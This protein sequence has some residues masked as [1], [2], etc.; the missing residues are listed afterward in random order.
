[1]L[2]LARAR[3]PASRRAPRSRCAG[4][5]SSWTRPPPPTVDHR[6]AAP[7]RL[8]RARAAA[9]PAPPTPGGQPAP[10]A[11]DGAGT[12]AVRRTRGA[13][14]DLAPEVDLVVPDPSARSSS[15]SARRTDQARPRARR[16]LPPEPGLYR[17]AFTLHTPE[18]VAYDAATQALL[19][20]VLVR[21]G[22]ALAV[23][24]GAPQTL[25]LATGST[26]TSRSG[27]S[28]PGSASWAKDVRPRRRA[29]DGEHAAAGR[30]RSSRR[31][32]RRGCPPTASRS[33]P[34]SR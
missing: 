7:G 14:R 34:R 13:G 12:R 16:R 27:C 24:Y 2:P 3:K 18:G 29:R 25:A 9:R 21:V 8:G 11:V 20:P 15:L 10:D 4:T 30:G 32:S 17:L 6:R 31:S 19:A 26:T 22:G 1:M 33:P 23:A 5:R 28:T